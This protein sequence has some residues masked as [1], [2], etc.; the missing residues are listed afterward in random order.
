MFV[1]NIIMIYFKRGIKATVYNLMVRDFD[2]MY[3]VR[4]LNFIVANISNKKTEKKK[5]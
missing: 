5:N 4:D 2:N 1:S 3:K